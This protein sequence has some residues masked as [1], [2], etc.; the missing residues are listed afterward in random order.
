[1][2]LH[3]YCLD[4]LEIAKQRVFYRIINNRH[5]IPD[6]TVEYKWREGY[7]NLNLFFGKF[8]HILLVDNSSPEDYDV[9]LFFKIP[10]YL[11][12]RIPKIYAILTR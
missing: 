7:K 1:M 3:F 2:E 6:D 12:E 10:V 11:R 8:D 9:D 5:F 4:S